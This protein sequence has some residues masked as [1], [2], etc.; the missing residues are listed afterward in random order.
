MSP[1]P[2]PFDAS[3]AFPASSRPPLWSDRAAAG[4]ALAAQLHDWRGDPQALVI[5]LPRGGVAVAAELADALA[6]PLST[7][8]VRKLA[9][10]AAPEV[11]VGALAPGGV[12]LWDEPYLQQ[13]HLSRELRRQLVQEQD[14]ELQRRQRLFADPPP[15]ALRGRH[16]LVVDDGVATGLT[17]RA[18]LTSLRRCGPSRLVLAVPVIDRE[19][20]RRLESS[21]EGLVDGLVALARVDRLTAVGAWYRHFEQL[22]D[23]SV[24]A[25]LRDRR[26]GSPSGPGAAGPQ[27]CL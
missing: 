18:A 4:Q 25:L 11:A 13:L 1:S 7:W 21:L 14:L 2:S 15:S 3:A 6:L 8:A 22:D 20:A 27:S 12:L 16:L 17:A 26:P 23:A 9:H 5:G 24:E 10:P 19:V